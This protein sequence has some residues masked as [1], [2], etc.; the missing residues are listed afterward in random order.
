MEKVVFY[1]KNYTHN[2]AQQNV[3]DYAWL[4]PVYTGSFPTVDLPGQDTRIRTIEGPLPRLYTG[5]HFDEN[6]VDG[7]PNTPTYNAAWEKPY[8]KQEFEQNYPAGDLIQTKKVAVKVAAL[9]PTQAASR[10]DAALAPYNSDL[11]D[12]HIQNHNIRFLWEEPGYTY[13]APAPPPPTQQQQN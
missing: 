4:V 3:N 13:P 12:Y 2:M 6:T 8:L 9:R 5:H 11:K 7:A 10:I 1:K